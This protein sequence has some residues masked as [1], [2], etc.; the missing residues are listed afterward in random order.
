MNLSCPSSSSLSEKD[1]H[2]LGLHAYFGLRAGFRRGYDSVVGLVHC[3]QN[4]LSSIFGIARLK[5]FQGK[6]FRR[7]VYLSLRFGEQPLIKP[8][9]NGGLQLVQTWEPTCKHEIP[10]G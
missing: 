2:I 9:Q 4:I 1:L 3:I 6:Y 7:G 10:R 8:D 5:G